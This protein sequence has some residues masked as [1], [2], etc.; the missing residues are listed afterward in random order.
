MEQRILRVAGSLDV[1][2]SR[3]L[4]F[5]CLIQNFGKKCFRESLGWVL[6]GLVIFV[7]GRYLPQRGNRHNR[8][9]FIIPL[10]CIYCVNP[11]LEIGV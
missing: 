8:L 3:L 9:N 10:I 1:D 4:L 2:V 6:L 7:I 5:T 11:S